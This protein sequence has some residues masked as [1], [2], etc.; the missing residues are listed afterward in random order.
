MT[1][2][3]LEWPKCTLAEEMSLYIAHQKNLNEEAKCRPTILV[4][5]KICG[6]S[7]G[8]LGEWVS[9]DSVVVND[10]IFWLIRWPLLQKLWR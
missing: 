4:S 6:Y 2:D 10:S 3:D 9:K 7:Q 1:L 8:L 5:R